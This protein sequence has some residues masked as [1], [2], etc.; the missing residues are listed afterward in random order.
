MT[1]GRPNGFTGNYT[2]LRLHTNSCD[3]ANQPL[4][5][6]LA[7]WAGGPRSTGTTA[8]LMNYSTNSITNANEGETDNS[9]GC[10]FNSSNDLTQVNQDLSGMPA[11]D[12]YG[13]ATNGPYSTY[14]RVCHSHQRELTADDRS[15]V[16]QCSRQ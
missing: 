6:V 16:D 15:S 12:I 7:Q 5:G 14:N 1:H 8:G 3:A 10:H 11:T 13:N 9:T 2:N 4:I